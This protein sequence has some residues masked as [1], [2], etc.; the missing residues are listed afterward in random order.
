MTNFV[1]DGQSLIAIQTSGATMHPFQDD[2]ATRSPLE[3]PSGLFI[4]D[5]PAF[6]SAQG[7]CWFEDDTAA[8]D[9]LR[10][11]LVGRYSCRIALTHDEAEKSLRLDAQKALA[12]VTTLAQVNLDALNGALADLCE[13]RWA[14]S[15]DEVRIGDEPFER[16]IQADFHENAFGDER[17]QADSEWADFAHHLT[18]YSG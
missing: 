4:V 12:G 18:R 11:R 1:A 3:Y 8:L 16:R 2:P 7:F 13:V 6:G 15:L 9:Y 14:G 5:T 10:W 17:G